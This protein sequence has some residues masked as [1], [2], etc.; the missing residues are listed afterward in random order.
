MRNREYGRV[1]FGENDPVR[2]ILQQLDQIEVLVDDLEQIAIHLRDHGLH[3][4]AD[5]IMQTIRD[6]RFQAMLIRGQAATW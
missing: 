6:Q 5:E 2:L 4:D 3:V 1:R